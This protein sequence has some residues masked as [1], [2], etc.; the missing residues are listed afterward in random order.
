VILSV[1]S[2]PASAP[3]LLSSTTLSLGR[4][5]CLTVTYDGGTREG[6]IYINGSRDVQAVFPGFSPQSVQPLTF[7]RASWFDGYYLHFVLDEARLDPL[8][9]TPAQVAADYQAFPPAPPAAAN[10]DIPAE[11]PMNDSGI[12]LM[13]RS[14]NGRHGTYA[15]SVPI[16]GML[17]GARAFNGASNHALTPASEA[18]SPASFTIRAWVKLLAYPEA[19]GWG[20]IL[21]NY[22]GNYQGWYLGVHASGRLIFSIASLPASSPWLLSSTALVPGRW[23][24]VA[25]T[26]EAASRLATIYIDGAADVQ[27]VL[28]G[29]TP[30]TSA[31][32]Y[33]G[34]A[35][36]YDGYYL[37]VAVDEVRLLG[38]AQSAL[39]VR[40][41]YLSF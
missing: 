19:S 5:Y 37:N 7:G 10:P 29:F 1:A 39:Q 3:W 34:R 25:A 18:F 20:V 41:D 35:S 13:D 4:W 9:L 31:D 36:W 26:Y 38:A 11:W 23:Y 24:H 17:A 12:T 15:G 22:G 32:L 14:G 2:L 8:S 30:N 16:P 21:S 33:L 27:S 40:A 6:S 28:A